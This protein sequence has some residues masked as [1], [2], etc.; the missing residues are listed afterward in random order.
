MHVDVAQKNHEQP[1]YGLML[2]GQSILILRCFTTNESLSSTWYL[3]LSIASLSKM[4][5]SI[6]AEQNQ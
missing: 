5:T 6:F 3:P 2:A 4:T 1:A